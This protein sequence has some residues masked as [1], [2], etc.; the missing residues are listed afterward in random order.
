LNSP[1][2]KNAYQKT[3]KNYRNTEILTAN[4]EAILLMLYEGAVRFL[5]QAIQ[6]TEAKDIPEKSRL[7]GR[8]QDIINELKATLNH[9]DCGELA[10]SLRALYDF[11]TDR[12]V[13]GT[14]ENNVNKLKEA[15]VVLTTL[16]NAWHQAIASLKKESNHS[17]NR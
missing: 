4:R 16:H 13:E 11:I 10:E 3:L 6:A 5:K 7:I 15:L 17:E 2:K 8:V 12:L 9:K 14:K 1:N